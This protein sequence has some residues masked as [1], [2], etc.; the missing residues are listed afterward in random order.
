MKPFLLELLICPACLPEER[1]LQ[2]LQLD[3][4]RRDIVSGQMLCKVCRRSYPIRQGVAFLTPPGQSN[5]LSPSKYETATA[6]SSYL[7]SHYGDLL[8][9]PEASNAYQQWAALLQPKHGLAID[10]GAAV[11][12]F[13][14]E[15]SQKCERVIGVD[16]SYSF[17]KAARELLLTREIE[18]E[19]TIEGRLSHNETLTLP[20]E[21]TTEKTDFIVG[22]ALALPFR[23]GT[24]STLASLNL[25]DK[26]PK[27]LQHLT[28]LNRIAHGGD[29][30]LL[31]SD[32]FSWSSETALEQ[33]WLGGTA[34]GPHAGR[35]MDNLSTLLQGRDNHLQP[36]WQINRQGQVWWKIRTHCNHFEL[37]RS[38][39]ITADRHPCQRN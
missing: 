20:R 32:P 38:C 33:E 36:A 5:N 10:I 15:L 3:V 6:L 29:A 12:R 35:G 1:P 34:E 28:E 13:S 14:F 19:L 16:S 7:W 30:Q 31:C 25:L 18:V 9:D 26:V 27:P 17:V 4:Q 2:A 37:I 24:F 8:N 39:Y 22:D 21:W 11:G 23:Q